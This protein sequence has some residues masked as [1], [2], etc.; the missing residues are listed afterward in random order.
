[1]RH[2]IYL[3][4]IFPTISVVACH[5]NKYEVI[6]RTENQAPDLVGT[7]S[8]TEVR[9]VLMHDGHKI[10]ASCDTT[11]FDNLDPNGRCSFRPLRTYECVLGDDRIEKATFPQSDLKCKDSDGHNVYLYVDK[12]E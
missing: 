12:K 11:T 8:H 7:G 10:Y 3:M 6:E 2:L 4:M 9:Y 5:P 1:M